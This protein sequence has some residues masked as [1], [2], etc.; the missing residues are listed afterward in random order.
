MG[1]LAGLFFLLTLL[2]YPSATNGSA[3]VHYSHN[4]IIL[5]K[6]SIDD[7]KKFKWHFHPNVVIC[8]YA[9]T[10]EEDVI[11]AIEWWKNLNYNIS[12]ASSNYSKTNCYKQ[13]P[14]GYIL[15]TLVSGVSYN[16]G[17]LAT[18]MIYSDKN[19]NEILWARIELKNGMVEDRVLEHE[20]GHALGWMH[21]N[22]NGHMMNKRL[23]DGGWSSD[24]LKNE[25]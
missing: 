20:I 22:K 6:R 10:T 11:K 14:Y 2:I 7:F 21:V 17:S 13:K 3:P 12:F 8:D 5:T 16:E 25:L 18:T 9:P 23:S 15:I 24:G 4:D 19:T 1:Y